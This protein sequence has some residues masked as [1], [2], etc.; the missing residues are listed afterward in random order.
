[1]LNLFLCTFFKPLFQ[2]N[3]KIRKKKLARSHKE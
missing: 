3:T 1:M 2:L